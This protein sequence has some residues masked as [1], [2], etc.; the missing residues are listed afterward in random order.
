M[1]G[2]ADDGRD[3]EKEE[4][5]TVLRARCEAYGIVCVVGRHCERALVRLPFTEAC[6]LHWTLCDCAQ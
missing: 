6:L 1:T 3:R 4:Q 5:R 2:H